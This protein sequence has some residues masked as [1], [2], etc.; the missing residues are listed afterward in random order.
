MPARRGFI[1]RCGLIRRGDES[2]ALPGQGQHVAEH[3]VGGRSGRLLSLKTLPVARRR[4]VGPG[5]EG[6]HAEQAE[7]GALARID[8]QGAL[9]EQPRAIIQHP[10]G[11]EE[12][13]LRGHGLSA[14][15]LRGARGQARKV[16]AGG[17]II[18]IGHVQL[19][20]QIQILQVVLARGAARRDALHQA[21][22]GGRA[23]AG[24][25]TRQIAVDKHIFK[26]AGVPINSRR[27]KQQDGSQRQQGNPAQARGGG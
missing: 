8:G 12:L 11:G 17:A 7:R 3:L 22:A 24:L 2:A 23:I 4:P 10:A 9:G 20:E 6:G 15:V 13:R 21:R 18:F 5:L 19:A 1:Q 25:Q 14:R 26:G 16:R 27:Q